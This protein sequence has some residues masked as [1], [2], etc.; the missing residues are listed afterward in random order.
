VDPSTEIILME[1]RLTKL[2]T[3]IDDIE[4]KIDSLDKKLNQVIDALIGNKL[5]QS[6]G[7][8]SDVK[9]IGELID[10]HE[11][12][13]NKA[14]WVWIGVVSVSTV[15]GFFLKLIFEHLTK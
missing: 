2:E 15:I 8:V 6:H 13:L 11:L 14:K 5:T 1:S 4:N 3:K 12:L 10:R 9:E 7:L